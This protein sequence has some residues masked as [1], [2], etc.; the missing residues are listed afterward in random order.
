MDSSLQE[1]QNS[2]LDCLNEIICSLDESMF[3]A[4]VGFIQST[5]LCKLNLA[6]FVKFAS[7][8]T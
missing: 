6:I 8:Y 7:L 2:V 5:I 3:H 1:L 4:A